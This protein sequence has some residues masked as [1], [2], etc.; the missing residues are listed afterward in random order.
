M[1]GELAERREGMNR[2]SFFVRLRAVGVLTAVIALTSTG[3]AQQ[4]I[5]PD[6]VTFLGHVVKMAPLEAAGNAGAADAQGTV[7][8]HVEIGTDGS[9]VAAKAVSG[10]A[11]LVPAAVACAKQ[12][13]F[14]PF[15]KDGKTVPADG[16]LSFTFGKASAGQAGVV[17]TPVTE[18][19]PEVRVVRAKSTTPADTPEARAMAKFH[20]LWKE[21]AQGVMR[22]TQDEGTLSACKRAADLAASFPP[23]RHYLEKRSAFVYAATAFANAGDFRGGELYAEQ[24]VALVKLDRK[25]EPGDGEVFSTLAHIEAMQGDFA[26]AD[27]N[28][29]TAEDYDRKSIAWARK[30]KMAAWI[31]AYTQALQADLRFHALVLRGMK[32]K[33]DAKEK[34]EEAKKLSE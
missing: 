28:L 27:G 15:E 6:T 30:N 33:H 25:H 12:W 22:H 14:R 31:P 17:K 24:A 5:T 1:D 3:F 32:R 2:R 8:L 18:E 16:T 21:C 11:A 10:P 7:V 34:L 23:D 9:V 20:P 29:T 19:K 13:K 26:D 4:T